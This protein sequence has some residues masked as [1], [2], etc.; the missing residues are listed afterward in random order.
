MADLA[1]PGS[2]LMFDFLH[3]DA[4]DGSASY[5]GFDAC[6]SVSAVLPCCA[7]MLCW[8]CAA[9]LCCAVLR[10]GV[11]CC[12]VALALAV[13]CCAALCY[14]LLRCAALLKRSIQLSPLLPAAV[15]PACPWPATKPLL[16]LLPFLGICIVLTC[17]PESAMPL[18]PAE[19]DGQGGGLHF[20][21]G[22]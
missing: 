7:V 8:C 10:C 11:L 18:I 9:L 5:V 20:R 15:L 4:V 12:T 17:T 1:A 22:A 13:L 3:A 6:Q 16:P 2:R 19:R 21:T 14:A